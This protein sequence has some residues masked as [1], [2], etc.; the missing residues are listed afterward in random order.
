VDRLA[1]GLGIKPSAVV[2]KYLTIDSDGDYVFTS[3]P[4]PFLQT[5]NYC[6][7]YE[8]RPKACREYPHTDRR[9][10]Q[11]IFNITLKNIEVCPVVLNVVEQIKKQVNR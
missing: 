8:H 4:C 1:K 5:D 2:E 9:K 11:Q 6:E 10:M 3:A 7:V